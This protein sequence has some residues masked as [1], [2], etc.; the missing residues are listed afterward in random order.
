LNGTPEEPQLKKK[1][2]KKKKPEEDANQTLACVEELHRENDEAVSF[3]SF[4]CADAHL[5]ELC[6]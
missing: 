5:V 4:C 6:R 3:K 2:K 1:K